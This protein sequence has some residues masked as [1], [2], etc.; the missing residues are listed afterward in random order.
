MCGTE[1][2]VIAYTAW[3]TRQSLHE[4]LHEAGTLFPNLEFIGI[5]ETD[6]FRLII[7]VG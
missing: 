6:P 7:E 1:F 2:K 4:V 5:A 3:D